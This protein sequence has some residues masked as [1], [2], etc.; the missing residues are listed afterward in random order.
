M[1]KFKNFVTVD[2]VET[3]IFPWGILQWVSEPRVT[4]THN[5]ATG[6]VT[7]T[8]NK[9]HGR[10]NHDNCEE[11]LYVLEGQ[12]LQ[13]IEF[14]KETLKKEIK[15]GDLIFVP[16]DVFHSTLNTGKDNLVFLAVYQF[17]GPEVGLRES[18][19]CKIELPKN[20]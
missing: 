19:D 20:K 7:L 9:G 17:S 16:A 5:M 10:H 12:G 11:V 1:S 4:G 15:K 8:P 2:D 18:P 3:Q 14:E 13:T 6:I